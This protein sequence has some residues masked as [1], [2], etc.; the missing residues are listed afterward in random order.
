MR[1]FMKKYGNMQQ[2]HNLLIYNDWYEILKV[3]IINI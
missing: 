3:I 2:I 1:H